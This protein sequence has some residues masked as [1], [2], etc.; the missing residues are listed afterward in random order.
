MS[1]LQEIARTV[2][3]LATP[4]MK[5]KDLV[6][7][8]R[9]QHPN[10]SKKQ[11]SRAAFMAMILA[12]EADPER[13]RRVQELALAARSHD[14]EEVSTVAAAETIPPRKKRKSRHKAA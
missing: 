6:A 5:P 2:S 12:A 13:A 9:Q 7:V 3:T 8:V 1:D 11:I 10:A 14:D 4:G